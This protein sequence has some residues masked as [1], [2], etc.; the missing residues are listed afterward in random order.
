[1]KG[2]LKYIL[3]FIFACICSF[4]IYYLVGPTDKEHSVGI[5]YYEK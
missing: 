1:M 4:I 5:L 2:S 3:L